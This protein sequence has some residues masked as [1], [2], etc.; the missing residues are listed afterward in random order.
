P[1]C[2]VPESVLLGQVADPAQHAQVVAD[3]LAAHRD[4]ALARRE[5]PGRE[6]HERRLPRAVR[7]EDPRDPGPELEVD[8]VERD[9][10]A[11]PLGEV[12]HLDDRSHAPTSTARIRRRRMTNPS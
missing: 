3:G 2:L 12:A 4:R 11:E 10:L 8:A 9:D 5:L 7:P 6:I 1:G